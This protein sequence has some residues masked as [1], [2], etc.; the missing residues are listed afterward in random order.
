MKRKITILTLMLFCL[1]GTSMAQRTF[2]HPGSILTASDLK[3]I[4]QHVDAREEPWY[5]SW[6]ELKSSTYGNCSRVANPATDIGGSDGTRQ[7]AGADATAAMIEAIEWH[8][9]GQKK[10]ADHAVKLLSAWGNK[11]ESA[12]NQLFQFPSLSMC[13]AA[14]MLRNEDGTFY[15][16]WAE[17][18]KTNF[19]NMVRNILYPANKKEAENNPMTSWSAPA[20]M[21]VLSAG[22]L[23]DDVEIYE[24]GLSYFRSKTVPGS[25]YCSLLDNGQLKEMGRDNVHAML[26]LNALAQMAQL[27]WCQGDDLWGEDNN[28]YTR[29]SYRDQTVEPGNTY[30]YKVV[31]YNRA[32]DAQS[33]ETVEAY[34]PE[35]GGLPNGW[36]TSG[37]GNGWADG[38][39]TNI[40]N[41]S[42]GC[43]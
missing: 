16:G 4:K 35:V 33:S 5:G 43:L 8:I 14:E 17:S 13:M 34:V 2:K 19:L 32:G 42:F 27:A 18:D 10:Y 15:E 11:V 6:L 26:T 12:N 3:R 25:V 9:T 29:K 31:L 40:L 21:A 23:L 20:M 24:E 22:L 30:Y 36:K 37:I 39:Y 7:R 41:N 38:Y 1:V 28:N